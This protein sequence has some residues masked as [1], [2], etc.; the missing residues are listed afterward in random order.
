MRDVPQASRF[1]V[2]VLLAKSPPPRTRREETGRR[3]HKGAGSRRRRC[4][5][6][7]SA[8]ALPN[9]IVPAEGVLAPATVKLWHA[10]KLL[11][12]HRASLVSKKV[13]VSET[14]ERLCEH[15]DVAQ[16]AEYFF[17]GHNSPFGISALTSSREPDAYLL[18]N[19][20]RTI[21]CDLSLFAMPKFST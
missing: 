14:I 5:L 2:G 4:P 6:R 1:L 9:A 17:D 20:T 8:T 19:R 10:L 13:A 21:G 16:L 7:L 3:G 18:L 11:A 12:D 15:Q